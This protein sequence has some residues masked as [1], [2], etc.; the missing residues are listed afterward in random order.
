MAARR[1]PSH[2][3]LLIELGCEELPPKSLRGLAD[4]FFE[5]SCEALHG[6]GFEF[7]RDGSARYY[8]PRRLA[9]LIANVPAQQPA[10]MIERRGPA[11]TAAF[12]ANG[13][14]TAAALGFARAVG[15]AVDEL[16]RV[17]TEQGEWLFC[18]WE[19]PGQTLGEWLFPALQPVL[20]GLP[21]ERPMRWSDHGFSFVRPVHWLL[22]MHG[23]EVLAGSL[24]GQAAG[25]QTLG[26][27][28]HSPGPHELGSAA[29]YLAL[30]ADASV[31]AD[32]MERKARIRDQ[33]QAAAHRAGGEC[34]LTDALL[35][36]LNNLVEW[37]VA[38]ECSFDPEFLDVPPE[39]LIASMEEHQRFAP[40][41]NPGDQQ[42]M[43]GFVAIANLES[44]DPAA[45]RSGFERVIRP[46]LADARFFW[47][48]DLKR[49]LAPSCEALEG[50]V[51]HK[52]L[53]SVGDKSRRLKILSE[54]IAEFIGIEP[55]PAGRAAKLAKCDLVSHMVGE[56]PGL[57]GTMGAYYAQATGEDETVAAAIG[58]H[59]RPRFSGDEIPASAH[60]RA[61]ALADRLDTLV[62]VFAAGLKP[63]GNKDPFALRRAALGVIR[64]LLEGGHDLTLDR[65]LALA[66][67][68]LA[69][70]VDVSPVVLGEVREFILER[71]RAHCREQGYD[72]RRLNAVLAAP[73]HGLVDFDA[74]LQALDAFMQLPEA[75]PL[76]AAN[77]RIGNILRDAGQD[78]SDTIEE[79]NL[80]FDEERRLF[81]DVDALQDELRP[82]FEAADY[83]P[84]LQRLAELKPVVDSFFDHVLVMDEDLGIRANRLALLRQL[85]AL[86]DRVA[87]LS[88]A[89]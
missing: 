9:V 51:F 27:R 66:A 36:E 71:L 8:T 74:R 53:G 63:S 1:R 22:V 60:G 6:A 13:E 80:I 78:I 23:D 15:R 41:L 49:G 34:R 46:R 58:E 55:E 73:L 7:D 30:L 20:D 16:E 54:K 26:H 39:A 25:R 59:Y 52:E 64:I 75:E 5:R 86:F 56:F 4:A 14:P 10:R 45:V 62:G 18:R 35:E 19:E 57:Q 79:D 42:L 85:K 17:Q 44:R 37:P 12:D 40:V 47:E 72:A 84:A 33:A 89:A 21:I 70:Q 69:D 82:L 83:T 77:K 81:E 50:V 38:I 68:A 24:L 67:N 28:L 48:Q 31:L 11:V 43:P 87:D 29:D 88:L 3:H 76:V 65:L 61:L 32:P 2:R